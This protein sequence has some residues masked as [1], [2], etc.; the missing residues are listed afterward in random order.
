MIRYHEHYFFE[1]KEV[2][3]HS[4]AKLQNGFSTPG[5][6]SGGFA[7]LARAPSGSA[8]RGRGSSASGGGGVVTPP[9]TIGDPIS[10][11]EAESLPDAGLSSQDLAT[12]DAAH[13]AVHVVPA[14]AATLP[15]AGLS[16]QDVAIMHAAHDAVH[17]FQHMD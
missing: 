3:E 4:K 15:D 16:S 2:C 6:D 13:D 9:P 11:S 7:G 8:A 14:V 12:M 17:G 10:D 5:K 1:N